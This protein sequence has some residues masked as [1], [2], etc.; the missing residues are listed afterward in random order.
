M[1]QKQR[2]ILI[3]LSGIDGSGKTTLAKKLAQT[4]PET[5]YIHLLSFRP[6]NKLKRLI[7]PPKEGKSCPRKDQPPG[8]LNFLNLIM[9]FFDI[10][11]FKIYFLALKKQYIICD[12][13]F[14]DLLISLQYRAP[15]MKI[16]E[17]L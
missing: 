1:A 3:S 13:Y 8:I 15:Q 2:K 10:F 4:L 7:K 14:Y 17:T 11:L 12:R 5:A 6:V 16:A 9:L